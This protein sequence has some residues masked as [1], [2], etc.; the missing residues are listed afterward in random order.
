MPSARL[1]PLSLWRYQRLSPLTAQVARHRAEGMKQIRRHQHKQMDWNCCPTLGGGRTM[2]L[3]ARYPG[4][5]C[6]HHRTLPGLLLPHT[7][8]HHSVLLLRACAFSPLPPLP[9]PDMAERNSSGEW[10]IY[11]MKYGDL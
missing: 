6:A 11:K 5:P 4:E 8:L 1:P 7:A 10:Y 2:D 3:G 9:P